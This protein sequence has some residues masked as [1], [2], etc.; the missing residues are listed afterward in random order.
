MIFKDYWNDKELEGKFKI[1]YP[2][3]AD[4]VEKGKLDGKSDFSRI[5][6]KQFVEDGNYIMIS[7]DLWD[8]K[9]IKAGDIGGRTFYFFTQNN[10]NLGT[11][12]FSNSPDSERLP[13]TM[14]FVLHKITASI[15]IMIKDDLKFKIDMSDKKSGAY[16]MTLPSDLQHIIDTLLFNSTLQFEYYDTRWLDVPLSQIAIIENLPVLE[17]FDGTTLMNFHYGLRED[18]IKE[19]EK[20]MFMPAQTYFRISL[21]LAYNVALLKDVYIKVRMHGDKFEAV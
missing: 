5:S 18:R 4:L 1:K 16:E 10:L 2:Y 12:Y 19:F 21:K 6:L 9:L 20:Y 15:R 11:L 7:E 8:T 13:A 14:F 3:L 17:T